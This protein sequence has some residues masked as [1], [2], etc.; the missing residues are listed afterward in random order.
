MREVSVTSKP[1]RREEYILDSREFR[2]AEVLCRI[3][4][5]RDRRRRRFRDEDDEKTCGIAG[6]VIKFEDGHLYDVSPPDPIWLM[7]SLLDGWGRS[8]RGIGSWKS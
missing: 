2:P 1:L 6:Y 7:S 3:Y 4:K 5:P 8:L